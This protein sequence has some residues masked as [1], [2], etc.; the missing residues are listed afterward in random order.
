MS[1]S[2]FVDQA[3]T[4]PTHPQKS[5]VIVCGACGN[6][7]ASGGQF[8]ADCGHSL[9]E[10]CAECTKPVLLS[11]SFCGKC[12]CD[13]VAALGKRKSD[14]ESKIA[15][16]IDAAKERDFE[17]SQGLLALV[18]R[19]T[20]YRLKDV[21]AK[22]KT[23]QQK[24]DLVAEQEC[25]S[26]SDRIAAAQQAYQAGDSARVVDLL[27][28]LPPK[29]LTPEASGNLER[30][31]ARLE[32]LERAQASL[33]EAFQKRDWASSGVILERLMELQPDDE[34]VAKLALKVGKKLIS[35]ATGLR[36][37]HKYR[38]ASE[39]LQCVPSNARGEAFDQ[40]SDVVD[41]IGWFA[42]QF[43]AE[44]FATA[45]L[46]RLAKQWAEKSGG[47]PRAIK[48]LS[49]ISSRI[50]GPKSSS[51]ELFAPLEA[52]S[53]SWVGGP[54]G[55][56]AF[57]EGVDI[58]D[59]GPLQSAPGQFNVA[60]GLALQGLGHGRITEDFSPKKGL[61][62]RLGRKKS[63]RCWGLD[64]GTSGLKAVC[65]ET[66][67][68]ERPRLVECYKFA[69]N[70]PL[71]RT[72]TD[73]NLNDAIREAVEGFLERHD[74]ESTPVWVSFP[75]RELVSR[76]VRLPPVADKQ[77]KTLF[78][79]EVESRI[80]LPLDEVVRVNWVAPLPS[81]EL[82][83]TGRPAFVSAAKQQFVDRYL[84]NLTEAGL[85]VSGLQATPIALLNFASVEFDPL[86][87]PD[88]EDDEDVESKLPTVA[89]VDCGAEMT[90]VL[91][92]SSASCWFW[93]FESGGNEFTRLVCRGTKL[94]HSEGE[95]LKRNPAAM[96][97]P[98]VQFE[99][100]EQRM[101]EMHGRLR[102]VIAD[103]A[104]QHAEFDVQ[105]TWCCGGGTLTH[106]W[107]KRILCEK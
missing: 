78:E 104:D 79:K 49:R 17:R 73:A 63:N 99:T 55:M 96:E 35:K 50:K 103:V 27:G 72:T 76:F 53:V 29:L 8:C 67:E 28:S 31:K 46:G 77:A 32:Q 16:A 82:T 93:S 85:T 59:N 81:E 83:S 64:L 5:D 62:Q 57:P 36:E 39:L 25:E 11:Q 70:T 100:V 1:G 91:M 92:I 69:F 52:K 40:L 4:I 71:T 61:L 3:G 84:E 48:T 102:K 15:D 21:V 14:L 98:Q 58:V 18:T 24:I 43:S 65:L 94:T 66:V 97:H 68:N 44:P 107:V 45:T 41:Q 33:Q 101:E 80:P 2:S 37:T 20:D 89:L 26:A 56:L 87:N 86:L 51:R 90:I 10:P 19:Q 38:A 47:D 42:N 105:Q 74:V 23:A 75:A 54:V 13:L 60:I 30:S 12:G 9:Y 106:G 6:P 7:N 88:Q 22:A 95:K 34:S